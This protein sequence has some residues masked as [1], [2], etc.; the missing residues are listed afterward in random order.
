M[1]PIAP[2]GTEPLRGTEGLFSGYRSVRGAYDEL[3]GAEGEI[4]PHWEPLARAFERLGREEIAFR[5]E[6]GSRI[7]R[8]HG[9]TYNV[10]ADPQG[11]ERPWELDLVPQLIPAS[12]WRMIETGLAQRARLLNLVLAD[13]YGPQ[14]LLREG[15]LPPRLIFANPSFLRACHGIEPP[16]GVHL[17]LHAV[18]LARSE[19]GQWWALA[20]RAQAPSGAGYAL[21]NRI[22]LSR[23]LPEEFRDCQVERLA[24]FFGHFRNTLQELGQPK[25]GA[26]NVVLLT[27]G[28]HNETYFEHVYLARYLGFTLVEGGDL[29]VRNQR[30]YIK[31]LEGL[32]PVDVIL[33]RVDDTFCDPVELRQDSFLGVPGLVEAARAGHVV[34]ANALGSGLVESPALL[35]FLPGL[36]RRL[37]D[38]ELILPSVATWWCGQAA[39]Q[40]YVTEHLD[41]IVVKPA[42]GGQRRDPLFG[43]GLTSAQREELVK[44][45]RSRPHDFVGQE[46]V[47]LSAAPVWT[48][49]GFVARRIAFRA[50]VA[51][52]GDSFTVLPGGLTRVSTSA[53]D[54]VVSMQRGGGSKDTWVMSSGPVAMVSL[55][56]ATGQPVA[57]SQAGTELPSR[58]ADNLYWLGRYFERLEGTVRLLRCVISRLADEGAGEGAPELAAFAH[59]MAGM[60]TLPVRFLGR[61]P[62]KDLEVEVLQLV[63]HP[64][65]QGG[66]RELLMRIRYIAGIVRDRLSGDTWRILSE[67]QGDSRTRPGRIPLTN[68]LNLLNTLI[69]DLSAFSGMEMENMTRGHGWRFLDVGRRLERGIN[70]A[71]FVKAGLGGESV[72]HFLPPLLEIADST[73]T[74]RRRYFTH[75]RLAS[76]LELLL[77]D[78]GN[79]RALAFQLNAIAEH[80][81]NL[82]QDSQNRGAMEASHI[83]S[84]IANLNKGALIRGIEAF[85]TEERGKLREWLEG[86]AQEMEGVSNELGHHYFTHTEMRAS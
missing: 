13:L 73:L 74:Y 12:E 82:P 84:M 64:T 66:I 67:L 28:P 50:F 57:L 7:I 41:E 30:V 86:F 51:A 60:Y 45:I 69:V 47:S 53:D 83:R 31:T 36:C 1:N 21:E 56:S 77:L 78:A 42:L 62:L 70:L 16:G 59:A 2:T 34:V 18:D 24:S 61:V 23:L 5:K 79:P 85:E 27:P 76:T 15:F 3:C 55:L 39:E 65:R 33:R 11:M 80:V 52:E 35:A 17:H 19:D 4:R 8:E 26:P 25:T 54:P 9:V 81:S 14:K 68:A 58:V 6:N 71:R 29:T 10:Y 49:G 40:S 43:T 72:E 38:E 44:L 48:E 22:V 63:Y 46:K 32:Q 37:L 20:D 75:P